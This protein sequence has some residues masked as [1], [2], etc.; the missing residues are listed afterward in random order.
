MLRLIIF[1]NVEA[2]LSVICTNLEK[3]DEKC[4]AIPHCLCIDNLYTYY[5]SLVVPFC[6]LVLFHV[7][8]SAKK[9]T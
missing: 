6:A 1:E 2:H 4:I 9:S 3:I 5:G 8:L 7:V